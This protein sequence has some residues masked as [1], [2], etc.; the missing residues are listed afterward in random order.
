MPL[1]HYIS[2]LTSLFI[3]GFLTLFFMEKTS[4]LPYLIV[5]ILI[6]SRIIPALG[7]SIDPIVTTTE[8][9]N[10]KNFSPPE[11]K[12]SSNKELRQYMRLV[13]RDIPSSMS[14]ISRHYREHGTV[15]HPL[16]D[17]IQLKVF[18]QLENHVEPNLLEVSTFYDAVKE[19]VHHLIRRGM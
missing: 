18:H 11:R 7:Q 1:K 12:I 19:E 14:L 6:A 9:R 16:M 4:Y 15:E 3:I 2:W 13:L 10:G 8:V 17:S 5:F